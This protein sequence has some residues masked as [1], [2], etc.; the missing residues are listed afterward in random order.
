MKALKLIHLNK[1]DD[2]ITLTY[3]IAALETAKEGQVEVY[4]NDQPAKGFR[5]IKYDH[6]ATQTWFPSA[7]MKVVSIKYQNT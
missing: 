3:T 5:Q 4:I 2:E 1:A 6:I 7:K